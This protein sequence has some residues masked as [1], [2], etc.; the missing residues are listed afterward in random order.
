M[1]ASCDC[2]NKPLKGEVLLTIKLRLKGEMLLTILSSLS[3]EESRSI[4]ENVKWGQRKKFSDGRFSM[5]YMTCSEGLSMPLPW[6]PSM[7]LGKQ[8]PLP[9][10]EARREE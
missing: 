1:G 9:G 10:A 4:S 7:M 8:K 2:I 5:C 6:L 3:Q